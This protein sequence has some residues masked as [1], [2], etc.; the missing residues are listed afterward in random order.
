MT[1]SN[2]SQ[3]PRCDC[4]GE[5]L[6][7]EHIAIREQFITLRENIVYLSDLLAEMYVIMVGWKKVG[8]ERGLRAQEDN[9]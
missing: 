7:L 4:C 9:E 3:A 2:I 1:Q 8:R 6:G 5:F